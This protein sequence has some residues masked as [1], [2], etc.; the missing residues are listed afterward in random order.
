MIKRLLFLLMTV[1]LWGQADSVDVL[2]HWKDESL[3]GSFA[4]NNTY[5]E[6]WGYVQDDK[7]YAIIGS[8]DGTHIFD[9]TDPA[10]AYMAAYIPGDFQGGGVIHRDYHDYDGYLYA[11]C[12]EG[13]SV[14]KLQIIDLRN[15]PESAEIV[16]ESSELITTSH[17]IFIDTASARLYSCAG[18]SGAGQNY[19]MRIYD[20]ADPIDP[21]LIYDFE[22]RQV[23][24]MYVRNDTCYMNSEGNGL[25]IVDFSDIENPVGLG[26]ITEY[27]GKGYNHSGW[28]SEDGNTYFLGDETHGMPVKIIDVSDMSDIQ[29]ITTVT[30]HVDDP[31]SIPH[32]ELA[33]KGY[34][35][36]GYYYDG[37]QIYDVKDPANPELI[38]YYDTSPLD[39][40]ESFEGA[41]G[42]YP[43]LPSGNILVN[44]MQE[45]LFV[46]NVNLPEDFYE[47]EEIEEPEVVEGIES[48]YQNNLAISPNLIE[49]HF[50]LSGWE[51]VERPQTLRFYSENGQ[52]LLEEKI[53]NQDL[54]NLKRPNNL[55]SGFYLIEL[56]MQN[57]ERF[58][59]KIVLK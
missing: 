24:D 30:S 43:F 41:W 37:L 4:F 48:L 15:L 6:I 55:G 18:R 46:L 40:A 19:Y 51:S 13:N 28:L 5:N 21:Q 29:V 17:N 50:A 47:S 22:P 7:E 53:N 35:F 36:V 56:M 9:V 44:D 59:G 49:S 34:L 52:L 16:Y 20:L 10:T 39:P 26:N 45:G 25:Y 57:G 31:V 11:V 54:Q 58:I 8:T 12:D 3:V 32:N 38:R 23:H 14:S 2:F 27:I 33:H 42:C 1:P